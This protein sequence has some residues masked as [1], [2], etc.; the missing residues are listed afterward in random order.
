MKALCAI[1]V[2]SILIG[3]QSHNTL[4]SMSVMQESTKKVSMPFVDA[5]KKASPSVVSIKAQMKP[6][7]FERM[8]GDAQEILRDEFWEKFFG[9]P[10]RSQKPQKPETRYGFGSGFI[11]SQDGYIMTN[12]HVVENATRITVQLSHGKEYIAKRV[13]T[14][15]ST[16]IALLKIEEKNLPTLEFADASLLD[17]GEWVIVIGNPLALRTSVTAGVVSAIGRSD[18]NIMRVE[19]FIQTD[20]AINR[21]NSGGPLINLDGKVVGM[22]TAI[23]SSGIDGGNIGIGFA[24]SSNLLEEVMKDIIANGQPTRGYLGFVPQSIDD[25]MATALG[26]PSIQGALVAEV[27]KESPAEQAGLQAGDV[28]MK[29]NGIEITSAGMLRRA[30]A[31]MKPNQNITL[32]IIRAGSDMELKATLGK[33]PDGATGEHDSIEELIGIVVEPITQE[34]QKQYNLDARHGMLIVDIDSES[35]AYEAGLRPGYIILSI[36]GKPIATKDEFQKEIEA[37]TNAKKLLLQIKAG[38]TIRFVPIRVE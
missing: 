21:G 30:I 32:S 26:L 13:G 2:G 24:I 11:V 1:G 17:I 36:N 31:L 19:E 5:A 23:L 20:A 8:Q 29:I 16:D 10:L 9:G 28:I 14:D 27:A 35:A 4:Y 34:L 33:N 38:P 6:S 18:L 12:N 37:G 15:P 7:R 25:E 3:S 22:A